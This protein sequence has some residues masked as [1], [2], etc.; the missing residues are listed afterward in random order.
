MIFSYLYIVEKLRMILKII[1]DNGLR[2][3]ILLT[4]KDSHSLVL[5]ARNEPKNFSLFIDSFNSMQQVS[6]I[7]SH[8]FY[9]S[10]ASS[11]VQA[12]ASHYY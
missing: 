8:K 10:L 11:A 5:V 3:F 2:K 6:S 12:N 1:Y 9:I 4:L 7:Y